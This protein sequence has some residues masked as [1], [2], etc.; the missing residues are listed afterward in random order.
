M[1]RTHKLMLPVITYPEIFQKDFSDHATIITFPSDNLGK[2]VSDNP[3]VYKRPG[4]ESLHRDEFIFA[5]TPK[6]LLFRHRQKKYWFTALQE[7]CTIC[8]L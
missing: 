3:F 4:A 6:Q 7:S 2:L 8:S 5:L 1:T